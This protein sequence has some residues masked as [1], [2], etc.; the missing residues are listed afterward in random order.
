MSRAIIGLPYKIYSAGTRPVRPA[1]TVRRGTV[2]SGHQPPMKN[3][4]TNPIDLHLMS[5][6]AYVTLF[7]KLTWGL[8]IAA[9]QQTSVPEAGYPPC[10]GCNKLVSA[11]ETV[12]TTLLR[13]P[14]C[15]RRTDSFPNAR[16]TD[17]AATGRPR[18]GGSDTARREVGLWP[19]RRRC[20]RPAAWV[21]SPVASC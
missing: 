16:C 15:S 3:T 19:A 20:R 1:W 6:I 10:G 14:S 5:Q 4:Q 13:G 17:P 12:R 7:H 21:W 18:P 11:K 8:K 9:A 2:V